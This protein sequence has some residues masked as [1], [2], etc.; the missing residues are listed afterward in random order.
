MNIQDYLDLIPPPNSIQPNFMAWIQANL[1]P[2]VDVEVALEEIIAAFNIDVAVGDQ[3]DAVGAILGQPRDIGIDLGSGASPILTDENYRIVLKARILYNHWDGTKDQIYD[4]WQ[5]FLPEYPVMILD[6]QDMSMSVLVIGVS[7]DLEGTFA[8]AYDY[9]ETEG[10][11][12]LT[13]YDL[14]YWFPFES[15]LRI[16]ISNNFFTPKPAGV[17]VNYEFSDQI[18]FAYDQDT[19]FLKGY[20]EGYWIEFN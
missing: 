3:L 7:N 17:S 13:G 9:L 8:F 11:P 2:Y 10:A 18:G 6:N 19:D 16:L 4:F 14:G 15:I 1:E 20:N 12:A 5:A